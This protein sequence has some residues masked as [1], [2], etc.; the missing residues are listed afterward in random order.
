MEDKTTHQLSLLAT[1]IAEKDNLHIYTDGSFNQRSENSTMGISWSIQSKDGETLAEFAGGTKHIPSSTRA[2]LT[3]IVTAISI[4]NFNK[5]INILTDSQNAINQIQNTFL[6]TTKRNSKISRTPQTNNSLTNTIIELLMIK[7]IK[8][9][10]TKVKGHS[11]IKGN[12]RA[13]WLARI[14][15]FEPSRE[16]CVVNEDQVMANTISSYWDSIYIDLPITMIIK[17]TIKTKW[18]SKW[19]S[20]QRTN[21]WLNKNKAQEI[22]WPLTMETLMPTKITS[23]KTNISDHTDRTFRMKVWNQELPTI[24]T[25]HKRSPKV[26]KNN[27]CK[28][29]LWHEDSDLHP[30]LCGINHKFLRGKFTAI[31]NEELASRVNGTKQEVPIGTQWTQTQIYN[32]YADST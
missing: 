32:E 6:S 17:N 7:N 4:V 9:T 8:W 14:D 31:L 2:E 27:M 15:P 13:D 19:R 18:A 11:G 16:S 24:D 29:C 3:A 10:L 28:I 1:L 5:T 30:F 22:N 25:L 26:Y 21:R 12:D 20:L 23:L